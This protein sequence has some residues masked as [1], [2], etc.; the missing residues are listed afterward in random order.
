M[1]N[2]IVIGSGIS[3]LV[4]GYYHKDFEVIAPV[5]D[6]P[7]KGGQFTRSN[8][9]W[10]HDCYET[11]RLLSDLGWDDIKSLVDECLVG[12]HDGAWIKDHPTAELNLILI[13]KKMTPWDQKINKRFVPSSSQLSM[14]SDLG[15][16]FMKVLRID[17]NELLDRLKKAV[18]VTHGYV[19]S[20]GPHLI[21]I[22]D[23]P[24]NEHMIYNGFD[25]LV[26]T[27]AAPYFW[28]GWDQSLFSLPEKKFK[29]LPI[30]NVIVKECPYEFDNRYE[31]IY[32]DSHCSWSRVAKHGLGY[33]LEFTGEISKE[34][35]QM[36]YPEYT[37][38]DHFVVPMGR[39]FSVEN[40]SPRNNII[41]SGRFAQW[42]HHITTEYV[43]NQ[44]INFTH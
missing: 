14:T 21:G 18:H 32:Y 44:S 40:I 11:R 25:W 27:I 35:F 2:N 6:Q 4:W 15:T 34:D 26:S 39:I 1:A 28:K 22:T 41:F 12:Y 8:M 23:H 19:M 20:I 7:A 42:Q 36:L 13:Q 43:I 10:L 5:Q 9:I 16:N 24:Q 3:G 38:L 17:L 30:T 37:V 29:H 31:M 33:T